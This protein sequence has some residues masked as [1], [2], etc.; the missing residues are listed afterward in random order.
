MTTKSELDRKREQ[1]R[2]LRNRLQRDQSDIHTRKLAL[3]RAV[4]EYEYLRV[5]QKMPAEF[6]YAHDIKERADILLKL[7]CRPL[8]KQP[9]RMPYYTGYDSRFN[10]T[11]ISVPRPKN[12]RTTLLLLREGRYS[13]A[14]KH[15]IP[16]PQYPTLNRLVA[17]ASSQQ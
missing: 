15:Y 13:D 11:M 16:H 7:W 12:Q 5:E 6:P 17:D 14:A 4:E 10:C 1:I 8:Y 9:L 3:E 2:Y